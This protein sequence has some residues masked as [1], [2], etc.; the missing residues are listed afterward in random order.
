[1]W[2]NLILTKSHFNF[3]SYI[4]I[5]NPCKM[6]A[7]CDRAND[8]FSNP[9]VLV[10]MWIFHLSFLNPMHGMA[11]HAS[12]LSTPLFNVENSNFGDNYVKQQYVPRSVK[13]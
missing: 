8:S 1:M 10:V 3:K 2:P 11:P 5:C 12:P 4:H 7:D 13:I 9:W 6:Q